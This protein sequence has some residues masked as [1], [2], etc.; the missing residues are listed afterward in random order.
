MINTITNKKEILTMAKIY[1]TK[2]DDT[3]V[4]LSNP[5]KRQVYRMG[6]EVIKQVAE[7]TNN[8]Q[9]PRDWNDHDVNAL[10]IP[11]ICEPLEQGGRFD[12]LMVQQI[13]KYNKALHKIYGTDFHDLFEIDIEPGELTKDEVFA[14]MEAH[15]EMQRNL[16]RK[17][18]EKAKDDLLIKS[19]LFVW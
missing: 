19:G 10:E 7:L 14:R 11:L 16:R 5:E 8:D 12:D 1:K 3:F 9:L 2:N 13:E 18:I 4:A 15:R 17:E 6:C